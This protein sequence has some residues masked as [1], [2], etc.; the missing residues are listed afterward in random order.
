MIQNGQIFNLFSTPRAMLSGSKQHVN[1]L[2]SESRT[3]RKESLPDPLVE[4]N[5]G[6]MC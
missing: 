1:A 4:Q 2:V 3:A 6:M 5:R